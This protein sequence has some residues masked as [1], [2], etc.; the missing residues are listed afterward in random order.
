MGFSWYVKIIECEL[1]NAISHTYNR[2][3]IDKSIDIK[4]DNHV[5]QKM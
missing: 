2:H 5:L 1:H 3:L 4:G